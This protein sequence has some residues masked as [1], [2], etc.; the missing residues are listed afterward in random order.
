MKG[1]YVSSILNGDGSWRTDLINT[2]FSPSDQTDI[3]NT[4]AGGANF[5]DDIIWNPDP[6]G[7]FSVKSAYH[8]AISIQRNHKV[9]TSF[10]GEPILMW[11]RFW[12]LKTIPKAKICAWRI[13]H[14]S[15]P[16][17]SNI[18]KKGINTN[19]LCTFCRKFE[20]TSTHSL[21]NCKI[22]KKN[23]DSLLSS[24]D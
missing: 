5:K 12:N 9:S 13:I 2:C 7:I 15:I 14:D 21:W 6:K 18:R 23:L 8:L 22:A 16:T 24:N 19:A 17:K 20:E 3:S 10:E 4:L 11:M 1:K